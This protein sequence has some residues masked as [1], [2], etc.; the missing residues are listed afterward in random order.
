MRRT[1]TF[2]AAGAACLAGAWTALGGDDKPSARDPAD[3][4][5]VTPLTT[6]ALGHRRAVESLR[7]DAAHK[8][9][10]DAAARASESVVRVQC[11]YR[12]P[13][14]E[15]CERGT[16]F[17]VDGRFVLTVGH[18]LLRFDADAKLSVKLADGAEIPASVTTR[19]ACKVP[20]DVDD[21]ALL[22]VAAD[23]P[24]L[25]PSLTLGAPRADATVVL[26]GFGG[27]AGLGASGTVVANRDGSALSPTWLGCVVDDVSGIHLRPLAG[28]VP[29]GGLSGAP[30]VDE[31]G[32][33]VGVQ[34]SK[35][36]FRDEDSPHVAGGRRVVDPPRFR[37]RVNAASLADAAKALAARKNGP[38]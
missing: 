33:V 30:V 34:A 35:T 36:E 37:Y 32:R 23:A 6:V 16:G 4:V 19:G 2:L 25:P 17:F 38:R 29:I 12:T 15:S 7:A 20:G 1:T 18:E 27:D 3:A 13:T 9:L 21:W 8:T 28:C 10:L 5:V 31:D 26:L 14:G 11:R 24:G 22:E